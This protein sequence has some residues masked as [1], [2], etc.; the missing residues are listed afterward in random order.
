MRYLFVGG[1]TAGHTAPL[2]AV[3]QAIHQAEPSAM[4]HY[5]GT[6]PDVDS[7]TIAATAGLW[8]T[9]VVPAGKLH[10]RLTREHLKQAREVLAG[11]RAARRL[12]HE[13]QPDVVFCKGGYV[14]VPVALAAH[15][16]GVRVVSHETDTV[17]GLANR[18]VA[19]V[20]SVVCTAWPSDVVAGLPR[21]KLAYTGQPVRDA[22]YDAQAVDLRALGVPEGES[23]LVI[24][25][26]SQGAAR[27]NE[28]VVTH[29]AGYLRMGHVVHL[30]GQAHYANLE[31]QAQQLPGELRARLHLLP[32][33]D[34]M[35]ELLHRAWLVVSRSGGATHEFAATGTPAVL[36]P[37]SSAAQQ[38]QLRNARYLAGQGAALYVE[39][40]AS[41]AAERLFS[42]VQGLAANEGD[43]LRLAQHLSKLAK[44]DAAQT[45]ARVLRHVARA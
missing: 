19:R 35:P 23:P 41:D 29:W 25:G 39:E 5:A 28:L 42:L 18:I 45:I 15:R 43:R 4:L 3:A 27:L 22:F 24:T 36:V 11:L 7:P 20:A 16:A 40:T 8:E 34:Q 12:I 31:A 38:H 6:Q 30:C 33:T 10:R 26:G 2:V 14:T 37:L 1:G 17:A 44:P 9:H 32:F 13:L 21:A